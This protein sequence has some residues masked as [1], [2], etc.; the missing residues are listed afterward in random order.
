MITNRI[1]DYFLVISL[2]NL[3]VEKVRYRLI[4]TSILILARIT[5]SA[6]VPFSRWLPKAIAAPTPVS[7]LVHSRTLVTA[8]IVLLMKI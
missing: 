6:M 2:S 5:K 1:G 4:I 8:G 7:A 3:V